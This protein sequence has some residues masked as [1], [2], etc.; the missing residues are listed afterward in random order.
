MSRFLHIAR[1]VGEYCNILDSCCI[2]VDLN[3]CVSRWKMLVWNQR[4]PRIWNLGASSSPY[5][6]LCQLLLISFLM[7]IWF[8][9]VVSTLANK[10]LDES[11]VLMYFLTRNTNLYEKRDSTKSDSSVNQHIPLHEK[12]KRYQNHLAYQSITSFFLCYY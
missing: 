1:M 10:F 11:F 3:A 4:G 9:H 2:N 7:K 12:A 5:V 8:R 6:M